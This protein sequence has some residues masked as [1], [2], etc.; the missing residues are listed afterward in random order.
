MR[1]RRRVREDMPIAE[2]PTEAE[3]ELL[4]AMA[5]RG[6]G[7]LLGACWVAYFLLFFGFFG[8]GASGVGGPSFAVLIPAFFALFFMQLTFILGTALKLH[9]G[10][11]HVL[12]KVRQWHRIRTRSPLQPMQDAWFDEELEAQVNITLD[13]ERQTLDWNVDTDG[14]RVVSRAPAQVAGEFPAETG[15]TVSLSDGG[16]VLNP[17]RTSAGVGQLQVQGT[18]GRDRLVLELPGPTDAA[19]PVLDQPAVALPDAQREALLS[20]LENISDAVGV[21]VP[22]AVERTLR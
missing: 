2:Q 6:H 18:R 19:V 15:G 17:A 14:A 1:L 9:R 10:L 21:E 5:R 8:L 7:F 11:A 22:V 4:T 16:F 20:T 13:E 3:L 12:H